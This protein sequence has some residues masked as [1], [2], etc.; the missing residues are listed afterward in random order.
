MLAV[1]AR[2]F[3]AMNISLNGTMN[4]SEAIMFLL[5]PFALSLASG[6]LVHSSYIENISVTTLVSSDGAPGAA[7]SFNF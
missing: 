7:L 6:Y 2:T 3:T 1:E 4:S 5:T